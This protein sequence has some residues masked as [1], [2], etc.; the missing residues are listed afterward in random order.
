[1]KRILCI[2]TAI[3]ITLLGIST[4]SF[5]GM[6]GAEASGRCYKK[7][8]TGEFFLLQKD[9]EDF[10]DYM[11]NVLWFPFGLLNTVLSPV[12]CAF[13]L[14]FGGS[15][16]SSSSSESME[17]YIQANQE[18]NRAT[19]Q[20]IEDANLS[21]DSPSRPHQFGLTPQPGQPTP[22]RNRNGPPADEVFPAAEIQNQAGRGHCCGD[23]QR[24]IPLGLPSRETQFALQCVPP[25]SSRLVV[26]V[27]VECFK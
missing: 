23:A 8:V 9:P 1:M 17:E 20:M 5:A 24:P 26:G 19:N 16:D 14:F 25:V 6:S 15:G 11:I 7:A 10:G 4:T 22:D 3:A 27:I 12:V 18:L 2:V 13:P 21:C